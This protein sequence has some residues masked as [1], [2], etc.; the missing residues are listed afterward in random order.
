MPNPEIAPAHVPPLLAPSGCEPRAAD[1]AAPKPLP[2]SRNER[3]IEARPQDPRTE[4][5]A[6]Y[7]AHHALVY[8]IALRYGKG[9]TTWAEDIMQDVFLDLMKALP[10]LDDREHLE[11]WLYKATT[12]RCFCR[13]RREK[14]RMLAPIRWLFGAE[15]VEPTTPDMLAMARQDLQRAAHALAE[16]PAKEQIAFSMYYLDGKEQD[17]IGEVLGHSKGYVCKLI[18]RAVD[19]LRKRGWEVP[20]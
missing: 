5:A 13:L 11:G 4:L 17:E 19:K 16:L 18:Q 2:A 3:R 12:Q 1:L 14:F 20:G 7:R 15:Q 9:N 10:T 6:L 8:R